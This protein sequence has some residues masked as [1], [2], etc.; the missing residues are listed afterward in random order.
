M[1]CDARRSDEEP[2][3]AGQAYEVL[4]P[5]RDSGTVKVAPWQAF[6]AALLIET[7]F[8]SVT[9]TVPADPE[10]AGTTIESPVPLA[11]LKDT[12]VTLHPA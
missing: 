5:V 8:V 12:L 1:R 2:P 4:D 11:A 6:T 10:A 9:V 7:A 3:A